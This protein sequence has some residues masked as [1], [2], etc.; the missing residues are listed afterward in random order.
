[1]P[2]SWSPQQLAIF[3]HVEAGKGSL[4][5]IA[6]AGTGKTT[7]GVEIA[8][9]AKGRIFFGAFNKAIADTIATRVAHNPRCTAGTFHSVGYRLFREMRQMA[10]VDGRKVQSLA[11][12]L[13]P[14]DKKIREVVAGAVSFAKLD[15]LGLDGM[16]TITDLDAW[17]ELFEVHDMADDIP[18]S[19]SDERVYRDCATVFQQSIEMFESKTRCVVDFDDMLYAPLYMQMWKPQRYDTVI[20]DEAQ[21]TNETR[22]RLALSILVDGGTLIAIGDDRQAIYQFAG[23]TSNAMEKIKERTHAVELPLSVTYRCPTSIVEMVNTIVPDYRAAE[24]NGVGTITTIEAENEP[25]ELLKF[26]KLTRKLNPATDV[27][28][29]RLTRPLVGIAKRLRGN[30]I[31]CVVEGN[32]GKAIIALMTKWG[33]DMSWGQYLTRM[34]DYVDTECKKFRAPMVTGGKIVM[35][36]EGNPRPKLGGEEKAEYLEEK[37]AIILDIANDPTPDTDLVKVVNLVERMFGNGKDNEEV[38]RL[39][40]VHRAKGREWKRVVLI[41]RNRYMPSPWAKSD[42]DKVAEENVE[43]VAITRTMEELVLVNVPPKPKSSEEPEWWEL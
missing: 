16:P 17:R 29:C 11:R 12:A 5:V 42:E 1:M 33:T 18:A 2:F 34:M 3:A 14:Y 24:T 21:D 15:G 38:L 37:R 35:D 13:Y 43:Y 6:R 19:I 7:T 20:V 22:L 9:R 8:N 31:P 10:Q 32:S 25:S 4:N 40:T 27:I 23:A 39:C 30:G 36:G 26:W 28:L 41:G